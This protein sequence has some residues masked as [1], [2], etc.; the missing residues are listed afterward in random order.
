[1][2]ISQW[3]SSMITEFDSIPY[4]NDGRGLQC[5]LKTELALNNINTNKDKIIL[6][7]EP[8]N[9]LSYSN[10]NNLIDILQENRIT[11]YKSVE[12]GA[13]MILKEINSIIN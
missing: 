7:V 12:I 5:L 10:M 8:E 1:M 6:I 11:S 2:N 9:H 3:E 13:F 4:S